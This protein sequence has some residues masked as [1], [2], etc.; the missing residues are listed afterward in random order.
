MGPVA[1]WNAPDGAAAQRHG[2]Q[3]VRDP[4]TANHLRQGCQH[5]G[6]AAALRPAAGHPHREVQPRSHKHRPQPAVQDCICLPPA[7][8]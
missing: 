8:H 2:R 4:P 5:R 3:R 7:K 6:I 1:L